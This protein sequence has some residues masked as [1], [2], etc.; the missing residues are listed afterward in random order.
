MAFSAAFGK[1][2]FELIA[3][4]SPAAENLTVMFKE[5]CIHFL[6]VVSGGQIQD[7]HHFVSDSQFALT[8]FIPSIC[9][10]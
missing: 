5:K 10:I 1:R 4:V 3:Y 9:D 2:E 6:G 8:M 7:A